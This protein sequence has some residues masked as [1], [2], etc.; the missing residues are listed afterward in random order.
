MAQLRQISRDLASMPAGTDRVLA[1]RRRE[2][3]MA[4]LIRGG[5]PEDMVY[6][7]AEVASGDRAAR[8]RAAGMPS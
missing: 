5:F 8:N 2:D 4:M 6:S 7:A 3:L 1:Q